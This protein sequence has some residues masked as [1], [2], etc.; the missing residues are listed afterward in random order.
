MDNSENK[1]EKTIKQIVG[2]IGEH[3]AAKYL[4]SR[5]FVIKEKNYRKKWGELDIIAEKDGMLRFVEV[6]SVVTGG[7]VSRVTSLVFLLWRVSCETSLTSTLN[8]DSDEYSPEEN[9]HLWKQRRMARAIQ[10]YLLEKRVLEDQEWQIDV[11]AVFLDF[12]QKCAT[13]RHLEDVVFDIK[14]S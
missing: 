3:L 2:D 5:H 8:V 1:K 9:I 6:K 13:I 7:F 11:I 10:T 12:F 14:I 4:I